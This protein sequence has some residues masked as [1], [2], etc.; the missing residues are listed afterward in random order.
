VLAL[1]GSAR[2]CLTYPIPW[3]HSSFHQTAIEL[4]KHSSSE[5]I[6][7]M[8]CMLDDNFVN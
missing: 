8:K 2:S 3:K 4:R 7:E 5:S 6:H 1:A